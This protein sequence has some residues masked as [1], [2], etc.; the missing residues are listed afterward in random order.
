LTFTKQNSRCAGT[1]PQAVAEA[2]Q[3]LYYRLWFPRWLQAASDSRT[4]RANPKKLSQIRN[5]LLD[6]KKNPSTIGAQS[7]KK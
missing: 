3:S 2:R 7:G 6:K 1:E 4:D 5:I